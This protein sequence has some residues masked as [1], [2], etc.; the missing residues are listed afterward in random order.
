MAVIWC[1]TL[2]MTN[3]ADIGVA[4]GI[5]LS[6]ISASRMAAR[7]CT[8]KEAAFLAP[9]LVENCGAS[10]PKGH[11]G[12]SIRGV[13]AIGSLPIYR[14]RRGD[15]ASGRASSLSAQPTERP[16]II[17]APAR[18]VARALLARSSIADLRKRGGAYK[19]N[20]KLFDRVR[21]RSPC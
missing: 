16:A 9:L 8:G 12:L 6:P 18:E 20:R 13:S 4:T 14:L 3:V 19:G 15:A 17:S 21:T 11:P 1:V 5:K 10:A 2:M 7:R